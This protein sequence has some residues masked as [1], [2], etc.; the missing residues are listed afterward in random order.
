MS[1]TLPTARCPS[2]EGFGLPS[3]LQGPPLHSS[4][5]FLTLPHLV[6]GLPGCHQP[7]CFEAKPRKISSEGQP[8]HAFLTPL[9]TA[10]HSP[11]HMARRVRAG[12][13]KLGNTGEVVVADG[14]GYTAQVPPC[15]SH[16]CHG[17]CMKKSKQ[18]AV[19]IYWSKPTADCEQNAGRKVVPQIP[20]VPLICELLSIQ[21]SDTPPGRQQS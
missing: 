14:A 11:H 6:A 10:P 7:P 5:P 16:P 3:P 15:S 12:G 20:D 21:L 2:N 8:P 1:S 9:Y 18:A 19:H 17:L 13:R 4:A